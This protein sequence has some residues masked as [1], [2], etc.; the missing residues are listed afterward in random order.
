[1]NVH[2]FLDDSG[3]INV[4]WEPVPVQHRLG[5]IQGYRVTART[6]N[7]QRVATVNAPRL[8]VE[9]PN[10][11]KGK[12]YSITVTAF[13]IAGEGPPSPAVGVRTEDGGKR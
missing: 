3:K 11:L 13:N 8:S 10:L 1:M 7:D 6:I 9:L 5:I 12:L 2:G 4:T